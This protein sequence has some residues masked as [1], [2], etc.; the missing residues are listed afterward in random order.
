MVAK[1]LG[2]K[3]GWAY[4]VYESRKNKGVPRYRAAQYSNGTRTASFLG[5]DQ[6][7][8][9]AKLF[10]LNTNAFNMFNKVQQ[11]LKEATADSIFNY[12]QL[13]LQKNGFYINHIKNGLQK[14]I[15]IR[16]IK[17]L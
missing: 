5:L 13:I 7:E 11:G 9:I 10:C 6:K 15:N 12:L 14:C 4:R 3:K 17:L 1:I 2:Y 8:T 16:G